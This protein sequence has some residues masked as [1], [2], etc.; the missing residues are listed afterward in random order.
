[1]ERAAVSPWTTARQRS[2]VK[3]KN[4]VSPLPSVCCPTASSDDCD[5]QL[6]GERIIN[7]QLKYKPY[8]VDG[9][10]RR[11]EDRQVWKS[12]GA[13]RNCTTVS[14]QWLNGSKYK[15]FLFF[16]V[17][18]VSTGTNNYPDPPLPSPHGLQTA[19]VWMEKQNKRKNKTY[20]VPTEI[21]TIVKSSQRIFPK[22]SHLSKKYI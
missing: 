6:E 2:V 20:T 4:K 3:K 9:T 21:S 14:G 16:F 7:R 11:S 17:F 22:S 12:S 18:F 1:M 19:S 13:T 10:R 5:T 8:S 15:A